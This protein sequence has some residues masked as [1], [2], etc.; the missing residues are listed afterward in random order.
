MNNNEEQLSLFECNNVAEDGFPDKVISLKEL[1][2][3]YKSALIDH[4]C[5]R[6]W[7]PGISLL[8]AYD[9]MSAINK[10]LKEKK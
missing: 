7:T 5:K 4:E 2:N 9:F 10:H 3:V 8:P 6:L 1:Y